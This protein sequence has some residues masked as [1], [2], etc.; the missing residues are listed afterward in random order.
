MAGLVPAIPI[1]KSA[2]PQLI[3]ITGTGVQPGDMVAGCSET[4]PPLQTV[5]D[6]SKGGGPCHGKRCRRWISGGSLFAGAAGGGEPAR[7]VPAVRHHPK[8]GYKW[9]GRW[10]AGEELADRSR[11]PHAQPAPDAMR[12]SRRA[13]WR[14]AMPIR[15]GARARSRTVSSA[16]AWLSGDLDGARD[17]APARPDRAAGRRRRR[18][19]CASRSRRR[20]CCGR[21]TSRAG[22]RLADGSRCH[23]L[24]VIDD[25]SRYR[26]VLGPVPMSRPDRAERI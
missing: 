18:P 23:P 24:T 16:R 20:T 21:W 26:A 9:L 19:S 17:P 4:W 6:A 10:A 22:C 1:Q 3:E 2:A 13:S 14:C 7:A 12:R 15:P 11:R 25:H 5:M 8:T